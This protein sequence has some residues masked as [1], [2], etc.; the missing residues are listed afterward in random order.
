MECPI[1]KKKL[2]WSGSQQDGDQA[3]NDYYHDQCG[4][5]L[6]IYQREEDEDQ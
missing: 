6:R 1:C 5:L 2:I 3:W 4:V